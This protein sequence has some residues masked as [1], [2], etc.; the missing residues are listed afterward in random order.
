MEVDFR[1]NFGSWAVNGKFDHGW[2]CPWI[3]SRVELSDNAGIQ[4]SDARAL[5]G[6]FRMSQSAIW[7]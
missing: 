4:T 6:Q 7:L 1:K 2:K 3:Y 5:E